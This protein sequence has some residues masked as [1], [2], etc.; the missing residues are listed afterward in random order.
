MDV[1]EQEQLLAAGLAVCACGAQQ[2]RREQELGCQ[3]GTCSRSARPRWPC[4]CPRSPRLTHPS[5]SVDSSSTDARTC[6][7][8]AEHAPLGGLHPAHAAPEASPAACTHQAPYPWQRRQHSLTGRSCT[9]RAHPWWPPPCPRSPRWGGHRRRTGSNSPCGWPATR[10]HHMSSIDQ[11]DCYA[12]GSIRELEAVVPCG[13]SAEMKINPLPTSSTVVAAAIAAAAA[14]SPCRNTRGQWRRLL[15]PAA[16]GAGNCCTEPCCSH[17]SEAA[18]TD[19]P[20]LGHF[21]WLQLLGAQ[22]CLV[23]AGTSGQWW[24]ARWLGA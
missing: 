1:G 11:V 16:A 10:I 21:L 24:S 18:A 19:L 4:L 8:A 15:A 9:G 6:D 14:P 17:S 12:V 5:A 22:H 13:W 7:C 2:G 20:E 23:A 3:R